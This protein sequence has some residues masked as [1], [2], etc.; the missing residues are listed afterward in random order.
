MVLFPQ[1]ILHRSLFS[2][3]LGW[4]LSQYRV[5]VY[6]LSGPRIHINHGGSSRA[7]RDAS[8]ACIHPSSFLFIRPFRFCATVF[9]NFTFLPLPRNLR[10]LPRLLS[11]PLRVVRDPKGKGKVS[12]QAAVPSRISLESNIWL[13]FRDRIHVVFLDYSCYGPMSYDIREPVISAPLLSPPTLLLAP[14]L[15]RSRS[16]GGIETARRMDTR[17]INCIMLAGSA[18]ATDHRRR[19]KC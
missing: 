14:A 9:A 7:F 19:R 16:A 6:K 8:H 10:F 1:S 2:F 3:R 15:P 13:L 12:S 18:I 4:L 17:Q 5:C 11:S